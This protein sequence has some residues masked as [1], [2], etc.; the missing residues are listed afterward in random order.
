MQYHLENSSAAYEA[1]I[2]PGKRIFKV[3]S[4][5]FAGR[6]AALYQVSPSEIKLSYSDYPYSLWST[7]TTVI[8][9]SADFPFDAIMSESGYIYIVYT[10]GSSNDLVL[11]KLTFSGGSW[12]IG[13]LN[14]IYNGDDNYFP[15]INA[16]P[17]GR[18]WVSWSRLS[19][20]QYYINA[21]YSDDDGVTWPTGPTSPGTTLSAAADLAY[22]KLVD[23]GSYNYCIYTLGT[24]KL[25][26][27]K[28]HFN[29]TLWDAEEAIANGINL[30]H[31]FDA[32]VSQDERIGVIFDD[33][34]IRYREY[35]G[36]VWGSLIDIDSSSGYFPQIKFAKNIPYLIYLSDFG[37]GQ[38]R[39]LY[40]CRESDSF[41]TPEV[42]DSRKAPLS[43][44]FCYRAISGNFDDL[45][46]AAESSA[47][48]D[49]YH[50]D[51]GAMLEDLG[52]TIYFGHDQKFNYLKLILGSSG[53]GGAVSW[54]YFNGQE[55][56]A[57]SPSGGIFD[58][59]TSEKELLLWDDYGSIPPDWQ[60]KTING[61]ELL[62]IR[63][64]VSSPFTI[65]PVGTQ[66]TAISNISAIV[67]ME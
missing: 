3:S 63:A 38:K 33:N 53:S 44:V 66:I 16:E 6:V 13:A 14:T 31:N 61:V 19:G 60:K 17:G 59:S 1:G 58:F 50:S 46:T 34:K 36:S 25:A 52:D 32:A 65:A 21:K 47:T 49:I 12:T 56:I 10:L 4:G 7:P 51:S 8:N 11:R 28:K 43:K 26:Y 45:T 54:Q 22:S 18:I 64:I 35:D 41:S 15:S 40:S 62:W 20:G 67:L 42:L 30:D 23:R 29:I 48:S 5:Q 24:T 9:D 27:R 55:W 37:T 57:F 39:I 2:S